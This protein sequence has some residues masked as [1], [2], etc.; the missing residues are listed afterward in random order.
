MMPDQIGREDSN[1]SIKKGLMFERFSM[2]RLVYTMVIRV[3]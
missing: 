1:P 3:L 2:S